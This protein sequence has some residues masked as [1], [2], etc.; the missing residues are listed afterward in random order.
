M[1][2]CARSVMSA[3]SPSSRN[4]RASPPPSGCTRRLAYASAALLLIGGVVLIGDMIAMRQASHHSYAEFKSFN[5]TVL[6]DLWAARRSWAALRVLGDFIECISIVAAV[7]PVMVL[8]DV[9]TATSKGAGSARLVM[10]LFIIVSGTLLISFLSSAGTLQ[11]AD[12]VSTF[13]AFK[14]SSVNAHLHDG[15]WGPMQSIEVAW[16]ISSGQSLWLGTFDQLML[17]IFFGIVGYHSLRNPILQSRGTIPRY[18][19]ILSLTLSLLMFL[20]FC[21]GVLRFVS[22]YTFMILGAIIG[23]ISALVLM[24]IWMFTLGRQMKS[25]VAMLK[26]D[27]FGDSLLGDGSSPADVRIALPDITREG[28]NV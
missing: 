24:P 27:N 20:T 8:S 11:R 13:P 9:I 14:P 2:V 19:S 4:G 26:Y 28:S 3:L 21:F 17:S 12:W 15:G 18:H 22:W 25:M 7:P 6:S 16:Q 1:C 10:P 5:S 23:I